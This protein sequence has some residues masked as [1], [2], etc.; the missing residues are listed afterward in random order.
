M[1]QGFTRYNTA[2]GRFLLR[3]TY[4]PLGQSTAANPTAR[5][6]KIESV[7]REGTVDPTD[8]TTYGN[9]PVTR[10]AATLVAY[11]PIA[12]TDYARFET[13]IDNR[14]GTMNLGVPSVFHTNG[15]SADPTPNGI[16]TPRRLRLHEEYRRRR[17]D[18]LP[19]AVPP[20]HYLRRPRMPTRKTPPATFLPNPDIGTGT[21]PTGYT[22]VAGGGSLRSNRTCA[23]SGKRSL[24]E[25]KHPEWTYPA[26]QL[27]W[28]MT[29]RLLGDCCWNPM[30]QA[31]P[32]ITRIRQT[33]QS[34][35]SR[36]R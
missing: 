25:P 2:N 21:A 28:R 9:Q 34:A 11:K 14:S 10:L 17:H 24:P 1:Q 33:C 18:V 12:I 27:L 32:C 13:N 22:V 3:V 8:P 6:L 19:A 4:D 29:L 36:L 7:G 23:C 15:G 20:R 26:V 35:T 30:I 16:V 5:Y 31:L